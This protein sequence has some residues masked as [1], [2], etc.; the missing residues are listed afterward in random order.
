M[1]RLFKKKH[2]R[3]FQPT[4]ADAAGDHQEEEDDRT[5][6][7]DLQ[8]PMMMMTMKGPSLGAV[9]QAMHQNI[10]YPSSYNSAAAYNGHLPQLFSPEAVIPNVS[11]TTNADNANSHDEILEGSQNLLRLTA[12]SSR[13]LQHQE[14]VP[15]FNVNSLYGSSSSSDWSFLDKLLASHQHHNRAQC[16]HS[17][18][19]SA[20]FPYP[21]SCCPGALEGASDTTPP[22]PAPPPPQS[23][24]PFQYL[25]Y[26]SSVDLLKFSK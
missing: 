16:D 4:E 12:S 14:R 1:C 21:S 11:S 15:S 18:P 26:D 24:F 22:P 7:V 8:H 20:S 2:H 25:G 23:L 6:H 19:S 17:K 5:L 3:G 9:K 13:I 10:L